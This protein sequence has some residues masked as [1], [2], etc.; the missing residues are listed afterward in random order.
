MCVALCTLLGSFKYC[1][2]IGNMFPPRLRFP[3]EWRYTA[4][5]VL[6]MSCPQ[7]ARKV[8]IER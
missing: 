4:L 3:Q 7:S 1:L 6:P 8:F 5:T 2:L